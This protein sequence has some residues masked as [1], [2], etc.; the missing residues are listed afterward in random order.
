MQH[1]FLY[2]VVT[3]YKRVFLCHVS[4]PI[5]K[6]ITWKFYVQVK[7]EKQEA[8][9]YSKKTNRNIIVTDYTFKEYGLILIKTL[10]RRKEENTAKRAIVLP[11]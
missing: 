11:L 3:S 7:Y 6:P 5:Q 9:V 2:P 1:F 8:S 4:K 10:Q